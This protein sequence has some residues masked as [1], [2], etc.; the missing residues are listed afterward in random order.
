MKVCSWYRAF[1]S[2]KTLTDI[3]KEN[4]LDIPDWYNE[5]VYRYATIRIVIMFFIGLTG[6]LILG[7][8]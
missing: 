4:R 8:I 1:A 3:R 2:K 6:G 7:H 5:T